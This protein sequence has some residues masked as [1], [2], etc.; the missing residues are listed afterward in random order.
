MRPQPQTSTSD[1]SSASEAESE[2]SSAEES[3][4]STFSASAWGR[5][6][7]GTE[8]ANLSRDQM[9]GAWCLHCYPSC[10]YVQMQASAAVRCHAMSGAIPCCTDELAVNGN[11]CGA[12]PASH[13]SLTC[14]LLLALLHTLNGCC[15]QWPV[16]ACHT[17]HRGC[18]RD[19]AARA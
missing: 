16:P 1:A 12:A 4:T 11:S 5:A 18:C 13:P 10:S 2:L 3:A 17:G 8:G 7:G 15:H 19:P 6:A 14:A 9:W